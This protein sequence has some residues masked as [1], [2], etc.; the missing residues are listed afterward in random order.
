MAAKRRK[1]DL[2]EFAA[3]QNQILEQLNTL[4]SVL[5]ELDVHS[6]NSQKLGTASGDNIFAWL[7]LHYG[8]SVVAKFLSAKKGLPDVLTPQMVICFLQQGMGDDKAAATKMNQIFSEAGP[9]L[10]RALSIVKCQGG[11]DV[12]VLAPPVSKCLQCGR[13]LVANHSCAVHCY[14]TSGYCKASKITLRCLQCSLFYNYAKYGDK[15]KVGFRFYP[16]ERTAVEVT[17]TIYFEKKLLE[18]Q[19][20]CREYRSV[21]I[22]S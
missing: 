15:R 10:K 21:Y 4:C 5:K 7:I 22:Y 8:T 12:K 1:L 9:S 18:L 2:V 19:C 3:R 17:D 20:F 14:S 16:G 11:A 6:L 13:R